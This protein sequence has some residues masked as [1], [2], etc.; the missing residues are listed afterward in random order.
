MLEVEILEVD[1]DKALQLGIT[2][3]TSTQ[4][5]LISPND[6]SALKQASDLNNALTILGQLF[7]ARGLSSIPGFTLVGGG[8]TTFLLTLPGVAAN[9][10]DA[11]NLVQSGRQVLLRAQDGKPAT[12]FV[13]DRFP[14]TLSLLSASLGTAA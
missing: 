12:F 10:S 8:Y 9:F 4:A 6:I 3:P 14:V 5:F 1:R 2:P 7:S 13:G 11:L